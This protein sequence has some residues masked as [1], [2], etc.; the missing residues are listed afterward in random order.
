MEGYGSGRQLILVLKVELSCGKTEV[1]DV[2]RGQNLRELAIGFCLEHALDAGKFADPL[3][4]HLS[5]K[6][7]Q[8][9]QQSDGRARYSTC[10]AISVF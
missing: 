5:Q 10:Q 3:E 4:K 1:L 6:M 7:A 8:Q 2:R 9:R